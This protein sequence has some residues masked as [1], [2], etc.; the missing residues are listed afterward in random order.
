[1][2]AISNSV[3]AIGLDLL[4]NERLEFRVSDFVEEHVPEVRNQMLLGVVPI[5]GSR[6]NAQ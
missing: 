4:E 6:R 5:T 3:P 2:V 1:M